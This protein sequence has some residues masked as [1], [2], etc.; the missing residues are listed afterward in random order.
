MA[1]PRRLDDLDRLLALDPGGRGIT[2][3]ATP[4]AALAAAHGLR[5]ARRVVIVTGFCVPPG[6]PETDG[7]PGAAVLGRALHRLGAHVRYV[8]DASVRGSLAAALSALGE[9][10]DVDVYHPGSEAARTLL[11]RETPSHLIAIERPGRTATGEYLSARGE[12][13]APWNSPLDELFVL[14][15]KKARPQPRR[16]SNRPPAAR[17]GHASSVT[18][19]AVGDGGNEIGMGNVRP[20]LAREGALMA[21][22]ASA[23]RVKYLVVAGVSNWGA[24]GIVAA[25]S[26]L[27]GQMLLHGAAEERRLVEACV[28]AGAVDGITRRPEPTVDGLPLEAHAGFVAL[29][30]RAVLEPEDRRAQIRREVDRV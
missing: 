17:A 19:F 23:V 7:P 25:L 20:R 10:P 2:R 5:R 13:V 11:A 9:P 28:E 8:T 27:S 12:S 30:G 26:R 3:Y 14:A 29:L 15:G 4:G 22:I 21:R 6:I 24:Y 1:A 16:S 18:T